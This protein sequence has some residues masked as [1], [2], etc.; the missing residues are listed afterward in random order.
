[1][2]RSE[3]EFIQNIKSKFSLTKVGDDCAILPKHDKTDLLMTADMLVENIDFRLD[4][5]T[6]EFLGHKAL[7]V[8][9]SDIAAM[10]G[11]AVWS[12]LSIGV[13]ENLWKTDFVD[14][15]YDGW[16]ALAR[17]FS[18]EL[19]G[20]DVSRTPD[21]V[22]IDSIVGGEVDKGR[23]ILR[24]TA[25]PGDAIFLTGTLGGAA[26]GLKL[27]ESGARNTDGL[28][29]KQLQPEPQLI[30]SNLLQKLGIANSMIDISDGLSSDLR[31][32]CEASGVGSLLTAERLPIH[33]DLPAHFPA[34]ECFDMT[35]NGG[36]D[37]ELLF[38]VSKKNISHLDLPQFTR[39]GE[40]TSN[41][42]II[43]LS[44]DGYTRVLQPKGY[45]H[46]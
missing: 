16:F 18:V 6:P 11:K 33:A 27:L 37:F 42:G 14:R 34:D 22:V 5:T 3:L 15:L 25:K 29:L 39:I 24:S 7:A 20:G 19:V 23:A 38:T 43:E 31:H 40:V 12:M 44:I 26:G 17:E 41:V 32:V 30:N 1:M 45:Q 21:K 35:L 8:S 36:E 2:S 28:L 10:G 4:W 13:P 46:F 9:L